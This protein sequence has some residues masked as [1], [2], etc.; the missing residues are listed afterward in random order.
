PA[1]PSICTSCERGCNVYLD[2][3]QSVPYRYRPRENPEINQYWMCDVGRLSYHS[4]HDDRLVR[5][6]VDG[7]EVEVEA[8]AATAAKRLA[9]QGGRLAVVVSPVLALEGAL[10]VAALAREG[11][12]ADARCVAGRPAGE[13]GRLSLRA[14]RKR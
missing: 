7:E 8:A 11:L 13:A 3:F 9:E 5:A 4:L 12:R 1:M 6:R 10:A 14:A 2:H